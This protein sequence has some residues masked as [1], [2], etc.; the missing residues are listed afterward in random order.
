MAYK[1]GVYVTEV[2]TA[3]TP[4]AS[5]S[6]VPVVFGTAPV[7]LSKRAQAP[8]NEPVLVFSY[9]EAVEAFG[10]S[11]NWDFTL[12]EFI[13]SHFSLYAMSP[14][15]LVNVLDPSTHKANFTPQTIQVSDGLATLLLQGVLLDTVEVKSGDGTT[16]YTVYT[17]Y[18]LDYDA[19]GNVVVQL[20]NGGA[21]ESEQ[22]LQVSGTQLDP[23]AVTGEDIIGGIVDGKSTGLELINQVFPRF[24]QVPS[25]IVAPGFSQLPEVAAVMTAKAGN[26]NSL[27]KALAL[28]DLPADQ[29]YTDAVAW[30]NNNSYTSERQINCYPKV[31]LGDKVYHLSTQ[32]A[33]VICR[34]NADNGGIPYVSPSNQSLQA[35]ASVL[36]N[37]SPQ[38]LGPDQA[39]YLNG[40]GIVTALNFSGGWVAWGN[41]TGAYPATTDP[42]DSFIPVRNMMDWISNTLILSYWQYLDAPISRRVIEAITDSANIWLNGLAAQGVIVGGRI[43]FLASENPETSLMDGVIKFHIYVTPPGPAREID[44]ILE[45]DPS[46]LAVLF[47]A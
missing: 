35:T 11:D 14:V 38:F 28:T 17:D 40:E 25:L 5:V 33:G 42:K 7:N 21:A 44:F 12:S 2:P 19:K 45:Y 46:Y 26:I 20:V 4:P 6:S 9:A 18:T 24:R 32:L 30:K 13:Y 43:E 41:R 27:F 10:Y 34:T 29:S 22:S 47:A 23:G 15:V 37:G 3:I 8:V 36:D 16:T 39:A 1:H 31:S